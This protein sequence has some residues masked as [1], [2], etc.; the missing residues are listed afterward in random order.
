MLCEKFKLRVE[1]AKGDGAVHACNMMH[2]KREREDH[3]V[4]QRYFTK[5]LVRCCSQKSGLC[6]IQP[7]GFGHFPSLLRMSFALFE[8][9]CHQH[10]YKVHVS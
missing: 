6:D 10:Q 1:G 3:S 8:L 7:S 4:V 5:S 9:A 2:V